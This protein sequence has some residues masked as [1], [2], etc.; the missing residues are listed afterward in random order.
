MSCCDEYCCNHGCNQGRNC[1]ARIQRLENMI[2]PSPWRRQ[3]RRLLVWLAIAFAGL[4]WI[5]LF[6]G[7]VIYA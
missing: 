7:A 1:P 5:A 2:T 4:F 6:M 3:L